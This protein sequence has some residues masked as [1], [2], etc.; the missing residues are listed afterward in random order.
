[1]DGFS[2]DLLGDDASY[3]LAELFNY[4]LDKKEQAKELYKDILTRFPGSVFTEESREKYRE[5]RSEYPDK[6]QEANPEEQFM[7]SGQKNEIN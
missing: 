1:V 5:L 4:N 3:L 2:Y 6:P 7:N